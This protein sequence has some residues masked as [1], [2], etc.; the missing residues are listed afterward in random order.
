MTIRPSLSIDV[1]G[2]DLRKEFD[3]AHSGLAAQAPGSG[4]A[5]AAGG[6]DDDAG[7]ALHDPKRLLMQLTLCKRDPERRVHFGYVDGHDRQPGALA[8]HPKIG[9]RTLMA[10]LQTETGVK[11]GACGTA[12]VEGTEPMPQPDKPLAGL[13]KKLR[14]SVKASGFRVTTIVLALQQRQQS[15]TTDRRSAKIESLIAAAQFRATLVQKK[16]ELDAL[17][18]VSPAGL[19][20]ADTAK[21]LG[22]PLRAAVQTWLAAVAKDARTTAQLNQAWARFPAEVRSA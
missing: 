4:G 14:A 11:T 2:L 16:G 5:G 22:T 15:L 21:A 18:Q 8:L 20:T 7:S 19:W 12:W 13:V 17:I 9:A 3:R 1:G 10:T 6:D